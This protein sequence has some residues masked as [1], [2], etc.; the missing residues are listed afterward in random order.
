MCI[1]EYGCMCMHVCTHMYMCMCIYVYGC[2]CLPLDSYST[3][4]GPLLA[5][6]SL[7]FSTSFPTYLEAS[8][9]QVV[10]W[11]ELCPLK[12]RLKSPTPVNVT[13]FGNRAF[14]DIIKLR[15]GHQGGPSIPWMF[16]LIKRGEDTEREGGKTAMWRQS[17]SLEFCWHKPRNA[18]DYH[19]L[20]E[21]E[22][23][24]PGGFRGSTALPWFWTY[25]SQNCERINLCC[26]KPRACGTLLQQLQET[27]TG[28]SYVLILLC[29]LAVSRVLE[30]H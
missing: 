24:S 11:V 14:A 20:A 8:W 26:C 6:I 5:L 18:R 9:S 3:V 22:K 21:T 13:S 29:G 30:T 10:S 1:C 2:A 15:W 23:D 17:Q 28:E 19:K 27:K 16:V 12:D 4:F 25:S 7:S